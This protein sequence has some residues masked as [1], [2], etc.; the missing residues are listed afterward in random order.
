VRIDYVFHSRR[1]RTV[2]AYLGPWDGTSDHRLV[3]ATLSL[4]TGA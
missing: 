2:E 4:T 1:W 3:G